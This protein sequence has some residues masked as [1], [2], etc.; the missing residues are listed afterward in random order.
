MQ[1]CSSCSN[2]L[3]ILLV[4]DL[5]LG[6]DAMRESLAEDP[7]CFFS[8]L[9]SSIVEALKNK[10]LIFANFEGA[11]VQKALPRDK[12]AP[13][14]FTMGFPYQ[15]AAFLSSIRNLTLSLS[16]NH[17]ADFGFQG[18]EET[19]F[20]LEKNGIKYIGVN[21]HEEILKPLIIE[22]CGIRLALFAF[23]DLLPQIFFTNP[24]NLCVAEAK[25]ESMENA[26]RKAR[27]DTDVVIVSLHIILD[28]LSPFNPEPDI[29]QSF[30][31]RAL[32]E[33]GADVIFGHQ[34][35]GLQ[36]TEL[37]KKGII[38]HGLGA[39]LY[40]PSLSN[41]FT[42]NSPTYAA[43]QVYGGGLAYLRICKHGVVDF[44]V[45]PTQTLEREDQFQ[46]TFKP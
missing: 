41:V 33:A 7:G 36:K 26:I 45:R 6:S 38:F 15:S 1:T 31:A 14:V 10:H 43:T 3:D 13:R 27:N 21:T 20:F 32:V 37:Y 29:K 28:I 11:I 16:N 18:I 42:P 23:T 9:D 44:E 4:G 46:V 25:L 35:H 34:Y 22:S 5:V 24:D 17:V 12:Q 30:L 2:L 19:S 39:F 40:D 8:W